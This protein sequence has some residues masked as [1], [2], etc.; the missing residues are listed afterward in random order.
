MRAKFVNENIKHLSPKSEEELNARINAL[1][2]KLGRAEGDKK[3]AVIGVW[4]EPDGLV[5][6]DIL[7]GRGPISYDEAEKSKIISN[8]AWNDNAVR[9]IEHEEKIIKWDEYLQK[10]LD[11][12][13]NNL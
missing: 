1:R 12:E 11:D 8:K 3:Y 2:D 6:W 13:D 5:E 10:I 7:S 4:K 9:D